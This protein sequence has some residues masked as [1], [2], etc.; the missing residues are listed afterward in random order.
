MKSFDSSSRHLLA[1][2]TLL[3]VMVFGDLTTVG[4]DATS[5]VE[6]VSSAA[7]VPFEKDLTD[8]AGDTLQTVADDAKRLADDARRAAERSGE[9][10]VESVERGAK[11]LR[12]RT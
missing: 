7:A 9:R 4:Q 3:L 6:S 2:T 8:A 5:R 10:L 12:V 11:R 1:T